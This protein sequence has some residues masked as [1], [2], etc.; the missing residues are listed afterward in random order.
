MS[1]TPLTPTIYP[2]STTDP[3]TTPTPQKTTRLNTRGTI[4]PGVQLVMATLQ[5]LY[6]RRIFPADNGGNPALCPVGWVRGGTSPGGAAL[7]NPNAPAGQGGNYF[8]GAPEIYVGNSAPQR[9]VWEPPGDGEEE[10]QPCQIVGPYIDQSTQPLPDLL[11]PQTSSTSQHY[12]QMGGFAAAQFAVRVI[13][14]RVHVW[15]NDEDDT[16][17]LAHW[18]ASAFQ[19]CFN[20]SIN[21]VPLIGPSGWPPDEKGSRGL[22]WVCVMRFA[23]PVHYPMWGERAMAA[24]RLRVTGQAPNK[25]VEGE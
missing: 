16:E 13:P 4:I 25:L 14:M 19:T 21:D 18:V 3:A 12:R 1:A 2:P 5:S 8:V 24:A 7:G 23:A 17:E 20:G 11:I 15:G 6:P 10:W 9:I 22:H